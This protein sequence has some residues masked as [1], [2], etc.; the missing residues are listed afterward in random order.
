M[1]KDQ[2]DAKIRDGSLKPKQGVQLIDFYDRV[3][4][5]YT[6]LHKGF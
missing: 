4:Q 5:D 3:L 2:V 1:L 6:Y